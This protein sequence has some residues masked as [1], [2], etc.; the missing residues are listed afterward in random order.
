MATETEMGGMANTGGLNAGTVYCQ[1][2]I[3]GIPAAV[4][5]LQN[6]NAAVGQA[7]DKTR[8]E[9]GE[10]AGAMDKVSVAMAAISAAG[11][12]AVG[13][14]LKVNGAFERMNLTLDTLLGSGEKTKAFFADLAKI[15]PNSPYTTV[16]LAEYSKDLMMAGVASKDIMLATRAV[17]E[18]TA[19]LDS[20]Q[21]DV[22]KF[23]NSIQ[24][25]NNGAPMAQRLRQ[26]AN[27]TNLDPY[28]AIA[29][30]MNTDVANV[31][32]MVRQRTLDVETVTKAL[33]HEMERTYGGSMQKKLGELA[34][35]TAQFSEAVWKAEN[36]L[37]KALMPTVKN[38]IQTVTHLVDR[39]NALDDASKR[40]WASAMIGIP[41]TALM[42]AG[43]T[44]LVNKG[45]GL[46]ANLVG[47]SAALREKAQA[48]LQANLAAYQA[49]VADEAMAKATMDAT[50]A[51]AA[52]TA[53]EKAA[54]TAAYQ[55]A[56]ARM[57]GAAAAL[58]SSQSVAAANLEQAQTAL[59]AAEAEFA[60]TSAQMRAIVTSELFTEAQIEQI[61]VQHMAA[62]EAL[63]QAKANYALAESQAA[64]ANASKAAA[65]T[66][67][68]LT[69]TTWVLVGAVAALVA[70]WWAYTAAQKAAI[71]AAHESERVT[72][73][74]IDALDG[75]LASRQAEITALET[76]KVRRQN[77][78]DEL[79]RLASTYEYLTG[80]T[81]LTTSE[82][83]RLAT[84][85]QELTRKMAQV[86][87]EL[88]LQK[89]AWDGNAASIKDAMA[90][91]VDFTDT[92]RSIFLAKAR[93]EVPKSQRETL[94]ARKE[95]QKLQNDI[96]W[97]EKQLQ[98][99]Q[100]I[101]DDYVA[102][103][104]GKDS[105]DT[106]DP[107]VQQR[108]QNAEAEI[109]KINAELDR[110][111]PLLTEASAK[112]AY[113][114]AT[115]QGKREAQK[116]YESMTQEEIDKMRAKA[117]ND[118]KAY[119]SLQ[120]LQMDA[121]DAQSEGKEAELA[122]LERLAQGQKAEL[123]RLK[124]SGA[125]AKA[126]ESMQKQYNQ[127]IKRIASLRKQA[128][129]EAEAEQK[130]T[131]EWIEKLEAQ[132]AASQAKLEAEQAGGG[133]SEADVKAVGTARAALKAG[134]ERAADKYKGTQD[135]AQFLAKLL[136]MERDMNNLAAQR[137]NV[138][139]EIAE[140]RAAQTRTLA[141]DL[142]AAKATLAQ[143][144]A[145]LAVAA[146]AQTELPEAYATARQNVI[147]AENAVKEKTLA[148]WEQQLEDAKEYHAI[149][150]QTFEQTDATLVNLQD[151]AITDEQRNAL[152]RERLAL[153][154]DESSRVETLYKL[155]TMS[156]EDT[157][158]RLTAL[159][160][161]LAFVQD[162]YT[163]TTAQRDID[164]Q[165][166]G[167]YTRRSQVLDSMV[168]RGEMGA[169]A[170]R[171]ELLIIRAR[172][173]TLE[174][175][176][177][178]KR[179]IADLDD[180]AAGFY[181]LALST[182]ERATMLERER[183]QAAGVWT[184]QMEIA[185]LQRRNAII[186]EKLADESL[187]LTDQQRVTLMTEQAQNAGQ[188]AGIYRDIN[189]QRRQW[190][191]QDRQSAK[192]TADA[193]GTWTQAQQVAFS[194]SEAMRK[195]ADYSRLL[196]ASTLYGGVTPEQL[197]EKWTTY[198]QAVRVWIG[199]QKALKDQTKQLARDAEDAN[200]ALANA[201]AGDLSP[202]EQAM[203]TLEEKNRTYARLLEDREKEQNA[204]RRKQL[205]AQVTKAK[206]DV[207][208]AER[209]LWKVQFAD[210]GTALWNYQRDKSAISAYFDKVVQDI[211]KRAFDKLWESFTRRKKNEKGEETKSDAEKLIAD[212]VGSRFGR[213]IGL[214]KVA[215]FLNSPSGNKLVSGGL[216][217]Y[218][219]F[220]AITSSDTT[221]AGTG[222]MQ[223]ALAG[224][225]AG[226]QIGGPVGA[227]VGA[228]A[229]GIFGG[230]E[231]R[232]RAA[233]EA[234][235]TREQMLEELRKINNTLQP[236][237][238]Y[239]RSMNLNLLPSSLT[240]GGMAASYAA[241]TSRGNW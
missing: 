33:F 186:E 130:A 128:G 238:D 179:A 152:A 236:M 102:K 158:K 124:A 228:L 189:E 36:A 125:N 14:V 42:I 188:I 56:Q 230:S 68:G 190:A 208:T 63:Q 80:K 27:V 12:A 88:G 71:E 34:G 96:A 72:Q 110:L 216:A 198:Q 123:Q 19:A 241:S 171:A 117:Q 54:A 197:R 202:V 58:A 8:E 113:L 25:L 99:N 135:G 50:L 26:I 233:Q 31:Y 38:G 74:Q 182:A 2:A 226:F 51:N 48:T 115:Y 97:Q 156:T 21:Q 77:L 192:E 93:Y 194:Q 44:T 151:S 220:S 78:H 66:F 118:E 120:Q 108:A 30:E 160:D 16:N 203:R 227:A 239:F 76:E 79:G 161:A 57:Q 221:N 89:K 159:R 114:G 155:G 218:G 187:K 178:V 149:G 111:R 153:Y 183:L 73:K 37:G 126:I 172:L 122:A 7:T 3:R 223:G 105:P 4:R 206:T 1:I 46:I 87:T 137:K 70:I 6:F 41:V 112:E 49:A 40:A 104:T 145:D 109:K 173:L 169:G 64:A 184:K 65:G 47:I 174:Q 176:E 201:Y 205:D 225:L 240:F 22:E 165:I 82:H 217:A 148:L 142:E 75:E 20:S 24:M 85:K 23:V 69:P 10:V 144:R 121:L 134:L 211:G 18:M 212:I 29:K 191:E 140:A 196:V 215:D 83:M 214:D 81:R 210:F 55:T 195:L 13:H 204:D 67:L 237:S 150:R 163:R 207:V 229:G 100:A 61:T 181:D 209:E 53:E 90:A 43:I 116:A 119:T 39:F 234:Q 84:T 141:D 138:E 62:T 219:A 231:A 32:E 59:A 193:A 92:E 162:T 11:T 200:I 180:E 127:T 129:K 132:Y 52:A 28:K 154:T 213:A 175:T 5:D 199:D 177:E 131:R 157:V 86:R 91:L 170:A 94:E 95:R 101:L 60:R 98:Q 224:G 235:R 136:G 106:V 15:Q 167:V 107:I 143:R 9:F 168:S 147:A 164:E 35:Q 103:Y 146:K 133:A 232:K 45:M 139:L 185:Y 17:G 222:A 166:L